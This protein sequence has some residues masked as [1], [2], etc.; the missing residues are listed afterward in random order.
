[1]HITGSH[2]TGCLLDPAHHTGDH[3]GVDTDGLCPLQPQGLEALSSQP[4]LTLSPQFLVHLRPLLFLQQVQTR[5]STVLINLPTSPQPEHQAFFFLRQ[6]YKANHINV[7]F[8][9]DM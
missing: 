8:S 7:L 4:A 1:M 6:S 9:P 2:I 5:G 3:Y